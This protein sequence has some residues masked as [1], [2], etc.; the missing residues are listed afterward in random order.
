ME[1]ICNWMNGAYVPGEAAL[2]PVD[3]P[4][5]GRILGNMR[6]A[7]KQQL[8]AAVRSAAKAQKDWSGHTLKSRA[9]VM[10]NYRALLQQ[11]RDELAALCHKENGKSMAEAQAG[12]D[13]ALE[14]A[15]FCRVHA[16]LA[17]G[18]HPDGQ[19]RCRMPR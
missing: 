15:E 11:Q 12:V 8:N 1:E 3:S 13:R 9:Q 6:L 4:L 14:L 19:P 5:D 17:Y 18:P 16:K 2:I 7:S 10:Y